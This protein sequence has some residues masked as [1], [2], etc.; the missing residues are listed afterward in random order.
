MLGLVLHCVRLVPALLLLAGQVLTVARG[1]VLEFKVLKD[2]IS[3]CSNFITFLVSNC[4]VWRKA[5]NT[6]RGW[7]W[8]K[9]RYCLD[10]SWYHREGIIL[11]LHQGRNVRLGLTHWRDML[12]STVVRLLVLR[13]R[14]RRNMIGS[15]LLWVIRTDLLLMSYREG[16]LLL[17]S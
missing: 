9:C 3:I 15:R 1:V 2:L 12:S 5:C 16:D 17:L 6:D 13:E 14:N 7:W 8:W 11:G 4:L 10:T